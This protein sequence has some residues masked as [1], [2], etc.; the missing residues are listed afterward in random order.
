VTI[1]LQFAVIGLGAG[2]CYALL[3]QGVVLVYRGSGV[4]N[5]AQGAF[6]MLAGYVTFVELRSDTTVNRF[7][8]IPGSHFLGDSWPILPA[9]VAGVVVAGLVSFLFQRLVL[10]RLRHAAPIVRVISTL[11]ALAVVQ[12]FVVIRYGSTTNPVPNFLPEHRYR[13]GGISFQEERLIVLGIVVVLTASLWAWAKYT[14]VGLAIT[15]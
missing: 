15:A 5:F 10:H 11:G 12:A 6:A 9:V 2:A 13:F 8:F 7:L 14:R 3:A 1:F 4:V